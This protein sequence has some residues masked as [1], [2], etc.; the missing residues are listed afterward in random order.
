MNR[1]VITRQE[2]YQQVWS[3][4]IS[5]LSKKYNVSDYELRKQCLV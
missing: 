3:E 4:P 2:L 1:K 5:S